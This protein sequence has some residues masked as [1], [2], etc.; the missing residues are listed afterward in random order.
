MLHQKNGGNRFPLECPQSTGQSMG[1]LDGDCDC[2]WENCDRD[3]DGDLR[4][5]PGLLTFLR[6]KKKDVLKN[7]NVYEKNILCVWFESSPCTGSLAPWGADGAWYVCENEI[8]GRGFIGLVIGCIETKFCKK[9]LA[10]KLLKRSTRFT[11]FCTAQTSIFQQ[12]CVK[13]FRIFSAFF[14]KNAIFLIF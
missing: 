9:I 13:L 1:H 14:Q 4:G 10:G 8:S 12:N 7:L 2:D 11:C 5:G 3:C 6:T